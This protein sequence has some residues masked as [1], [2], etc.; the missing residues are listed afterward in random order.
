MFSFTVLNTSWHTLI[1]ATYKDN[2]IVVEENLREIK[3]LWKKLTHEFEM[4]I[5]KPTSFLR[6]EIQKTGKRNKTYKRTTRRR[7][8]NLR[9]AKCKTNDYADA[10]EWI[11]ISDNKIGLF[12]FLEAIESLLCLANKLRY[13]MN[14]AIDLIVGVR[15]N[16]WME[17]TNVKKTFG[18]SQGTN[19]TGDPVTER[20]TSEYVIKFCGGTVSRYLRKQSVAALSST[21]AKLLAC[22]SN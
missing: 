22:T 9:N 12:T 4:N 14:Y 15:R 1:L 17:T 16:H 20:G 19:Y 2:R 3:V 6:M 21:E 5:E 10:G 11:I 8:W 18:C 13:D 7:Y